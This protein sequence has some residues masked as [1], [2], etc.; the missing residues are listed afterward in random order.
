MEGCPD[1]TEPRSINAQCLAVEDRMNAAPALLFT[2]VL[3]MVASGVLLIWL[4]FGTKKPLSTLIG[5]ISLFVLGIVAVGIGA[6][7]GIR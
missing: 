5:S 2:A 1:G 4:Q 3:A 7:M 6:L